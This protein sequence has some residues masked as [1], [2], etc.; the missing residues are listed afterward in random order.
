MVA[1]PKYGRLEHIEGVRR[2]F[3]SKKMENIFQS[4]F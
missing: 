1:E 2:A 4:Y 3:I